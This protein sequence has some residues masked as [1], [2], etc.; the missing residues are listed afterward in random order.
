[1]VYGSYPRCSKGAALYS[2]SFKFGVLHVIVIGVANGLFSAV[3]RV[4][5]VPGPTTERDEP[6][7]AA[8]RQRESK[9]CTAPAGRGK[10][11]GWMT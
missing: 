1:M 10:I 5:R 9:G 8:A 3:Q 11:G 4:G 7:V 6:P 2:G